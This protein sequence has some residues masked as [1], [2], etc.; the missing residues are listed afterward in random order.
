MRKLIFPFLL[1]LLSFCS[2]GQELNRY[3]AQGK[4]NS[5]DTELID[6][7]EQAIKNKA[8]IYMVRIDASNGNILIFTSLLPFLTED[9][10]KSFFGMYSHLI[11]CPFIGIVRQDAIRTFPFEDCE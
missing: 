6:S 11:S 9:E 5:K 1:S 3:F 7:V 8:G 10:F 2:I 4:F